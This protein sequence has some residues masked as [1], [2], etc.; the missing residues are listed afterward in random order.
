MFKKLN[1]LF[2]VVLL[3]ISTININATPGRLVGKSIVECNGIYYGYHGA[4]K[5]WHQA[6][7]EENGYWNAISEP[8][9][10]KNP[11]ETNI[12]PK[13]KKRLGG[14]NRQETAVIV[15][16]EAY[17][18]G[19]INVV[20]TGVGGDADALTGTL[21]AADKDAPLLITNKDTLT[22]ST[23]IEISRLGAKTVYILGGDSAVS[24]NVENQIRSLDLDVIRISGMNRYATAAN[25]AKTVKVSG[26]DHAFL[27][28]G[29]A[30][31]KGG[32][33]ADAL[34][35]GPVSANKNIPVLLTRNDKLPSETLEAIKDLGVS[36]ITIVG[37][38]SAVSLT[39][40]KE[41]EALGVTVNRVFGDNRENTALAIAGKYFS[42]TD[43]V[44]IANGHSSADALVGGYFGNKL[45]APILLA[46]NKGLTK[47]TSTYIKEKVSNVYVLGGESV[48]SQR[49]YTDIENLLK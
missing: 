31:Q 9:G 24:K 16:N 12:V 4:D 6:Q 37:G 21:L 49:T 27:V 30:G 42:E 48:V 3:F 39:V 45:N 18:N 23:K 13:S 11:C 33:L 22:E 2:I 47:E 40:E 34:A 19:A 29:I 7:K 25:V 46:T 8:L 41:V 26:A 15:S 28:L 44:L 36:E 5:H 17:P 38:T 32:A 20:L 35:I 14:I 10:Y 43:T 1:V